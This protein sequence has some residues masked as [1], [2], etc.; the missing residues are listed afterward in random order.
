VGREAGGFN[1]VSARCEVILSEMH[2][3]LDDG[4][5]IAE[6]AESVVLTTEL[7]D[8]GSGVPIVEVGN[9]TSEGVICGGRAIEEGVEPRGEGVGDV[10]G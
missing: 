5:F 2:L 6:M 9:G 10:L 8:L 4:E 7:F 1:A 3:G